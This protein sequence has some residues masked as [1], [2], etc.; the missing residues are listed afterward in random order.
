MFIHTVAT[1]IKTVDCPT[2][3]WKEK[4][5]LSQYNRKTGSLDDKKTSYM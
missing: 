5:L 3:I 2:A 1:C 4:L